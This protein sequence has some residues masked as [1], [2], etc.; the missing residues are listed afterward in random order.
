MSY[1]STIAST[2]IDKLVVP[3]LK[4]AM[5]IISIIGGLALWLL[6]IA[7][8]F[9]VVESKI[10][11]TGWVRASALSSLVD[12]LKWLL[13][14]ISLFYVAVYVITYVMSMTGVEVDPV[15]L[16]T[17]MLANMFFKPFILISKY[18]LPSSS[19]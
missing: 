14:G 9:K 16:A 10:G 19:S 6:L 3:F 8:V 13:I 18:V 1:N 7:G 4:T 12:H 11:P 2:V 5:D 17:R 15:S